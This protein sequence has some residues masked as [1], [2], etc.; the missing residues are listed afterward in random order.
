MQRYCFLGC[1]HMSIAIIEGL[2]AAGVS[3][4]QITAVRRNLHALAHLEKKSVTITSDMQ[5]ALVHADVIFLG[6]RPQQLNDI[7]L[8]LTRIADH[9]LLVSMLA[10]VDV[11]HLQTLAPRPHIMRIMPNLSCAVLRGVIGVYSKAP[12]EQ[13]ALVVKTLSLLGLVSRVVDEADIDTITALAGSGIA[14]FYQ[15]SLA[16]QHATTSSHMEHQEIER[17]VDAT[18]IG[19]GAL[20]AQSQAGGTHTAR[21]LIDEIAVP[22]GTTEQALKAFDGEVSLTQLCKQA[23]EVVRMRCQQLRKQK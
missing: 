23:I 1:G 13:V 15:L 11:A 12:E 20:L 4:Q 8:P 19:A 9:Q 6:V 16:L 18:L 5:W 7:A 21:A 2:L 3:P 10:A 17:I 22:G 14:Y